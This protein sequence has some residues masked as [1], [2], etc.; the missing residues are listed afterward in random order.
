MK[1]D[2]IPKWSQVLLIIL[3]VVL[4]IV[5]RLGNDHQ[6]DFD[7]YWLHGMAESIQIHESALWVFHPVSLF[8]FYP[9]SY[10]S[11]NPF[12][13][14]TFSELTGLDINM[15]IFVSSIIIGLLVVGLVFMLALSLFKS[16]PVAYLSAFIV[17]LSPTFIN[18]TSFNAGGRVLVMPF[19]LLF[20]WSLIQWHNHRSFRYGILAFI[21]FLFALLVHRTAVFLF[22]I[23]FAFILT[24]IYLH[25]P[26]FWKY[27]REHRHYKKHIHPRYEKSKYY[28]LFDLGLIIFIF[29]GMKILDLI[30]R[31]RLSY[32]LER[33]V[34]SKVDVFVQS[35]N[36]FL[37]S[38]IGLGI[39]LFAAILLLFLY[40][41][42][43][44]KPIHRFLNWLHVH[45]HNMFVNPQK[46]FLHALL[47]VTLV[48]FFGQFFGNSF[49][50]PSF[51]EYGSGIISGYNPIA[52][53]VNSMVNYT[54]AITFVF[55]FF[56][57]GFVFLLYKKEKN[58]G[59]WM[60]LFSFIMFSGLLLDKRYTRIFLIPFIGIIASYGIIKLHTFLSVFPIRRVSKLFSSLL[61]IFIVLSLII[62]SQFSLIRNQFREDSS[63]F[64]DVS[65]EWDTG[66]YIR[67]IGDD[68]STLTT[69]ELSTGVIIFASSGVPGGSHN[70]Y[71]FVDDTYL[72][73]IPLTFET[74]K[75]RVMN[76]DKL[77]SLWYLEDWV[78]NGQ[79]YIGRH[80]RYTF[81]NE[82][83]DRTNQRIINDYHE[84][85][86]IHDFTLEKND[87]LTSIEPVKNVVY[88]T[89]KT[90]VYD[91]EVGR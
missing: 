90:I 5:V 42:L 33:L 75:D 44:K 24:R 80:A 49:Y 14:A 58:F 60:F 77:Q 70:I 29:V 7:S 37:F 53:F 32:N 52:I 38:M 79:Y 12:F 23:L 11:G 67:S 47:L 78:L 22:P 88:M 13:L 30:I 45:Y 4:T 21:S 87:F 56:F 43:K 55:I 61:I 15:S 73:P 82:F 65:K 57:I 68:F 27:I 48:L 66:Q 41:G 10:P 54:T 74:V 84:R 83:T 19:I 89:P 35:S 1:L 51:Y 16:K 6:T 62:G 3:L 17:S 25:I 63:S 31:G 40:F 59:E 85:F 36:F 2:N 72:K 20:V 76:G 39:L 26:Y 50:A 18:Y 9:I 71:Y 86:Y 28:L 91:I 69:D 64:S 81:N 8:G 46:Y 34:F